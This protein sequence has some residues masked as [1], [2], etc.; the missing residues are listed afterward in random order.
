MPTVLG[1]PYSRALQLQQNHPDS[2]KQGREFEWCSAD[3]LWLYCDHNRGLDS[4]L[5]ESIVPDSLPTTRQREQD[6]T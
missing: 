6:L 3:V 5:V 2:W 1:S 4:E